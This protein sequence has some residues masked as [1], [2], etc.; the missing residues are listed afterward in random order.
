MR[1]SSLAA[2]DGGSERLNDRALPF[3]DTG[4]GPDSVGE[5]GDPGCA[6]SGANKRVCLNQGLYRIFRPG[7]NRG[8]EPQARKVAATALVKKPKIAQHTLPALLQSKKPRLITAL[9][10]SNVAIGRRFSSLV[11]G[12]TFSG[13]DF[14]KPRQCGVPPEA[15]AVVLTAPLFQFLCPSQRKAYSLTWSRS[16]GAVW[17]VG[18]F[19][20]RDK[21]RVM[22]IG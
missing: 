15:F 11:K 1:V 9:R 5:T 4:L 14:T 6:V 7:G 20:T 3:G 12:G 22:T 10:G 13:G 16:M 2:R 18:A 17:E 8:I 19:R 21:T